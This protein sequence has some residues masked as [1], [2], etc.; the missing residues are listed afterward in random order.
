MEDPA[1]A[2]ALTTMEKVLLVETSADVHFIVGDPQKVITFFP[3]GPDNYARRFFTS[4][5]GGRHGPGR[6]LSSQGTSRQCVTRK[7]EDELGRE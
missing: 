1:V 7:G 3:C 6:A 4:G 5:P 2:A